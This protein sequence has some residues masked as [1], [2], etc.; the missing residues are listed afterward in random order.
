ME[1]REA[2]AEE[3]RLLRLQQQEADPQ[4]LLLVVAGGQQQA[5]QAW[6]AADWRADRR[7]RSAPPR[8]PVQARLA[9]AVPVLTQLLKRTGEWQGLAGPRCLG[10]RPRA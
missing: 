7:Q 6:T 4:R 2:Y 10:Q 9:G 3:V 5:G 8:A 1:A